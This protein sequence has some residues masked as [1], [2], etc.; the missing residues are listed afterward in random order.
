MN[1]PR[2]K[3]DAREYRFTGNEPHEPNAATR[4]KLRGWPKGAIGTQLKM[5]DAKVVAMLD[6]AADEE[7]QGF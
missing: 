3:N 7:R 5:T 4:L 2:T 1:P 6:K